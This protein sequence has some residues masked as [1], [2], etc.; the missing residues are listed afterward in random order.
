MLLQSW[1]GKIRVFPA[2]PSSW[3]DATFHQ[4]RAEGAFLVSASRSAGRTEWIQIESLAGQPATLV[5]DFL[6]EGRELRLKKGERLLLRAPHAAATPA[7]VA[8]VAP[9][10]WRL[11]FY[12]SRKATATPPLLADAATGSFRLPAASATILGE[13]LFVKKDD[14]NPALAYWVKPRDVAVW[15]IQVKKPG[16]YKI[17]ALY[18]APG[19]SPNRY[20]VKIGE[21]KLVDDVLD[22]GGYDAPPVEFSVGEVRI[23][24]PGLVTVEVGPEVPLSGGLFNLHALRLTPAR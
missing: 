9:Q 2:V 16:R 7:V 10:E 11:N 4:L 24:K 3:P 12:G 1:G 6:P 23:D 13:S 22:S 19:N 17:S 14:P 20:Y 15:T 5:A 18:G 21:T 8:P